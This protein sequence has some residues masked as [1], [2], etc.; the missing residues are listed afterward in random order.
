MSDLDIAKTELYEENLTIAIVKDGRVLYSTKSHSVSGLLD[1]IDQL[2]SQLEGASVADRVTGKAIALLCAYARMR[3][4]YA[5]VL[6]RKGQAV[7]KQNGIPC[8]WRE[9]VNNILDADKTSLCP[10]EKTATGISDPEKAYRAFKAL[11]QSLSARK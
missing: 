4:V 6:S 1:A 3:E 2:G 10:F 9:L 5:A 7:F 8:Q 11:Q